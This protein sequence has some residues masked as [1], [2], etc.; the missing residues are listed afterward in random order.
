MARCHRRHQSDAHL[1]FLH[2]RIMASKKLI[3]R[4]SKSTALGPVGVWKYS[5]MIYI[6]INLK[7]IFLKNIF[8]TPMNPFNAK[9]QSITCQPNLRFH[10]SPKWWGI[11]TACFKKS[12]NKINQAK[13]QR[14][15]QLAS[16]VW[17]TSTCMHPEE[18]WRREWWGGSIR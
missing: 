10:W 15:L 14:L 12:Q 2:S 13:L 1:G 4:C 17:S 9:I 6:Y 18:K 3:A 16:V 5:K 8:K 11:F 7:N